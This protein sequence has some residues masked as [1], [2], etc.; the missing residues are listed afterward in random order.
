MHDDDDA[1]CLSLRNIN[2]GDIALAKFAQSFET[3]PTRV[4]NVGPS[5]MG[6]L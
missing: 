5:P 6:S 3:S 4:D 1:L 2:R